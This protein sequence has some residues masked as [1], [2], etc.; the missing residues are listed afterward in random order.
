MTSYLVT[1]VTDHHLTC[2][3][4]RVRD[5]PT[6]NEKLRSLCAIVQ[7]KSQKNLRGD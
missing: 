6:A 7:K 3:K 2:L 5:K 1:V 4:L